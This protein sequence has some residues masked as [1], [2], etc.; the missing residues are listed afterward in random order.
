MRSCRIHVSLFFLVCSLAVTDRQGKKN[1]QVVEVRSR[2]TL[3]SRHDHMAKKSRM[4]N[5]AGDF[6]D[7]GFEVVMLDNRPLE[8]P[9]DYWSQA[10]VINY[11][12]AKRFHYNFTLIQPNLSQD[13]YNIAWA[14]CF[15]LADRLQQLEG[16]IG[17]KWI[18]HLDSDAFVREFDLPLPTF[19]SGLASKYD[20]GKD[21]AAVFAKERAIK[22]EP[23]DRPGYGWLNGGVFLV[24]A[25]PQSQSFF[26]KWLDAGKNGSDLERKTW[27]AEMGVLTHL[28]ERDNATRDTLAVV[29]MQEM[30]SPYGNY[31]EHTWSGWGYEMRGTA[32][33][34]MLTRISLASPDDFAKTLQQV[35]DRIIHYTPA[36]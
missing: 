19:M 31:V 24:Q 14:K 29:D 22:S 11:A 20:I 3:L 6:D 26:R 9:N 25:N 23:R 34:D 10:A 21:V 5:A 35:K 28:Y 8:N 1:A 15:Y 30:N 18:L 17:C 12:Y 2:G 4:H 33:K 36:L 7:C 16:N 13:K 32:Y 27:P